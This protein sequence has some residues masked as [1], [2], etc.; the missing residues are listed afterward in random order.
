[1]AQLTIIVLW[2]Q[3]YQGSGFLNMT[4]YQRMRITELTKVREAVDSNEDT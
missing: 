2:Y 3:D 4:P 1:V